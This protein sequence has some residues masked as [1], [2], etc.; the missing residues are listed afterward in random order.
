M[1]D[2]YLQPPEPRIAGHCESCGADLY[3][4]CEYVKDR[5]EG[6]WFCDDTCYVNKRRAGGDLADETMPTR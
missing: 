6:E 1:F 4:Y 5:S 2:A 3:A